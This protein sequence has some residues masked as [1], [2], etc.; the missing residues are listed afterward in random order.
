MK[1]ILFR[2]SSDSPCV[3]A[4]VGLNSESKSPYPTIGP[5]L[6][7]KGKPTPWPK[8]LQGSKKIPW[9]NALLHRICANSTPDPFAAGSAFYPLA[10]HAS[11]TASL[12]SGKGQKT[13]AGSGQTLLESSTN[14]SLD[15]SSLKTSPDCLGTPVAMMTRTKTWASPQMTLLGEWEPFSGI[16]PKAGTMRNGSVYARPTWAPHTSGQESLFWPT[17]TAHDGRRPGSDDSSTMGGNLKREAD[18]WQTPRAQEATDC[19]RE[20]LRKSPSV[21]SQAAIWQTPATDSFRSRGGDRVDEMGLDQQS[22]NWATPRTEDGESAGNHP[23]GMDS[24][25]GQTKF[26]TTPAASEARLGYQRRPEGMKSQQNQQSLSTESM[27]RKTPHGMSGTDHTGKVGS[28]GEFHKQVMNWPTPVSS[29][30]RQSTRQERTGGEILSEVAQNWKS[31]HLDPQ[32]QTGP[33]CWCNTPGCDLPSHK[34]KL[35][36]LFV[37]WLM[38]WPIWWV[39]TEPMRF[40]HSEMESYL[41][42]ARRLL[43][44]FFEGS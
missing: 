34:R 36:P 32:A 13:N 28:G 41:C 42:N 15:L 37:T 39:A 25:T 7:R 19:P 31:S 27:T 1:W 33:L 5:S 18:N 10:S 22:R 16:W 3:S 12:E 38:G 21:S 4:Q 2:K 6:F 23:K 43:R 9:M 24:L 8:L 35:N 29:Q 44:N 30:M 40:A 14:A 26:W 11:L 20:R 17:A